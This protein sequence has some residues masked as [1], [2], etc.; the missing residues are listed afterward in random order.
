MYMV[1]YTARIKAIASSLHHAI[2]KDKLPG[3]TAYVQ[4]MDGYK[5]TVGEMAM[6]MLSILDKNQK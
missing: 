5:A 2:Y 4:V 1:R 6:A 3:P